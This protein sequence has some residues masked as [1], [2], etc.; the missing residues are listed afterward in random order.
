ME[1]LIFGATCV[2]GVVSFVCFIIVLVKLFR[3]EGVLLG[4][5]GIICGLYTFIWGWVY[6]EEEEILG[7]MIV[8]SVLG[9]MQIA[10]QI[11][12]PEAFT[13]SNRM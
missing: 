4:I 2:G 5:L 12:F 6:H 8:W 11:M 3:R 10:F 13:S 7:V 1:N 9:L